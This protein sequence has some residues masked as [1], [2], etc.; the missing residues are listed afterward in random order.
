MPEGSN[1]CRCPVD[2]AGGFN[3]TETC[4]GSDS[5]ICNGHGECLY[6][7]AE[8][9]CDEGW[10][11]RESEEC[12]ATCPR[13]DGLVCA[14]HGTCTPTGFGQANCECDSGYVGSACERECFGGA[15]NPCSGHGQCRSDGSSPAPPPRAAAPANAA[16]ARRGAGA[17]DVRLR[18]VVAHWRLLSGVSR[19][20]GLQGPHCV[21]LAR[22]LH[23]RGCVSTAAGEGRDA[24]G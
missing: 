11:G 3:C 2:Y 12:S 20:P 17:Q 19:A 24:S 10:F 13:V 1:I 23:R 21:Q 6:G 15:A 22:N 14:G 18:R 8:C 16:R 5:N 9:M 4:P 7:T